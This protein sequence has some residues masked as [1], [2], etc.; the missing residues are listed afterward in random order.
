MTKLLYITQQ[1]SVQKKIEAVERWQALIMLI[2]MLQNEPTMLRQE[3]YKSA[4]ALAA[5]EA[6]VA[7][8]QCKKRIT[9]RWATPEI[10]ITPQL[11]V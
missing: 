6:M 8:L 11:K 7:W 9:R 2:Q 5:E 4:I 10:H 1:T 3:N